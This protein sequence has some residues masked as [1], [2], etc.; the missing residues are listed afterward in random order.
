M[1]NIVSWKSLICV[2]E[3]HIQ[4]GGEYVSL[5]KPLCTQFSDENGSPVPGSTAT[6]AAVNSYSEEKKQ[7]NDSF[8]GKTFLSEHER[9]QY[10][11]E[12][13]YKLPKKGY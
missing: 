5:F 1:T 11:A 6:E 13:N 3:K 10:Y 12:H 4:K 8:T 2:V 7:I 9:A